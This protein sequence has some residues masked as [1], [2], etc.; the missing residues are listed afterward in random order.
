[1]RNL[2]EL[3]DW[4]Q[5]TTGEPLATQT[6]HTK[7]SLLTGIHQVLP[8]LDYIAPTGD[9]A[10][11]STA[12][13]FDYNRQYLAELAQ[14][15]P[16]EQAAGPA[17][18]LIADSSV[19]YMTEQFMAGYDFIYDDSTV[20]AAPLT[21]LGTAYYASGIGELYARS[22]W[23]DHA[24]WVNLIGGPYTESH[25]HQDQGSLMMYKDGWLTVDAVIA[26]HSGLR[27]ETTAHGLVRIDS[28]NGGSPI[29]QVPTTTSKLVALHRGA[30]WLHASVDITAAYAGNPKIQKVVREMIYLLPDTVVVY[31]RV[32]STTGTEQTWQ[33]PSPVKPTISGQDASFK[34]ATH[35][36]HVHRGIPTSASS[37]AYSMTSDSSGD[38]SSGYR[39]DEKVAGGNNRFLH[40]LSVD[41][42]VKSLVD[43]TD[44]VTVHLASGKSF[45]CVFAHDRVGGKL[46]IG[47]V[48]YPLPA[49]IQ[50]LPE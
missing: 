48:T 35:T 18:T 3:Y 29:A 46:E 39:L 11:D 25:A 30:G 6:P 38:Y 15:F 34:T 19:P 13:F 10:R 31:D 36:L 8:T 47:G 12:A 17:K 32:E 22:G 24:T 45:I 40:V 9:Q 33:L 42:A 43:G 44:R 37:S 20:K 27:Q 41:G 4:W 14:M 7:A 16:T 2:W 26:S 21:A 1:M 28:S 49:G 23:D 50:A 5:Q